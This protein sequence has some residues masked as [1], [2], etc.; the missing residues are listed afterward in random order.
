MD[1]FDHHSPEFAESWREQYAGLRAACPMAHSEKHGGFFVATDYQAIQQ[2]LHDP[3]NFVCG[4]DLDLGDG[5][6]ASGGVTVP[7]NAVRMGMMEMDPPRS[8]ALRKIISGRFTKRAVQE[9]QPRMQQLVSWCIDKVIE[10]GSIDFVDD[11]ANPLP[12]LI[13][14]DYLGL[15]LD[16]WEF[17]ATTL[18]KA[19]Y[20]EKGSG[21]AVASMLDDIRATVRERRAHPLDDGS[22]L[23][24]LLSGEENGEPISE[25][26]AVELIF[27]LLNGGIDTTTALIANSFLYFDDH[28]D[29]WEW[30]AEDHSRLPA[31]VDELIR[32]TSPSTGVARTVA[33]PVEVAGVRL[34]IGDRVLLALGSANA[35]DQVF[36][37]PNEVQLDRAPNRHLSFGS[38]VHRCLGAFVA[39]AEMALLL[40]EVLNRMPDYRIDREK[41]VAYPTI[42]LV[43]GYIAMPATFTPGE[44]VVA[45]VLADDLPIQLGTSAASR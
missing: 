4:R 2:I 39:P 35:D 26:L 44:K 38:G 30:L 15:P 17:Y 20:R 22:V 19:A 43:N 10:S 36:D 33:Q 6:I 31:A 40:Q 23:E 27:M 45:G 5:R 21:R 37:N 41:V 11:I 14:L 1:Q 28:R 8:Q 13:T 29:Q 9:Y 12:A 42:P 18:H 34:D 3:Q 25:D 32:Y 24:Q 7:T 16:R